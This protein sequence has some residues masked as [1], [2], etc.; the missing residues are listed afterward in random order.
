[1]SHGRGQILVGDSNGDW[2]RSTTRLKIPSNFS[3]VMRDKNGWSVYDEHGD[4]HN[5]YWNYRRLPY[6]LCEVNDE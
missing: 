2:Y 3:I 6:D 4:L 5:C 1:M